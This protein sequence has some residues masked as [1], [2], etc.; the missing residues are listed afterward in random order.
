MSILHGWNRVDF[1]VSAEGVPIASSWCYDWAH[2]YLQSGLLDTEMGYVFK[3]FQQSKVG[4]PQHHLINSHCMHPCRCKK[5]VPQ[6]DVKKVPQHTNPLPRDTPSPPDLYVW[7]LLKAAASFFEFRD[8]LETWKFTKAFPCPE[9]LFDD[10]QVRLNLEKTDFATGSSEL[11]SLLPVFLKYFRDTV[12][13]RGECVAAVDSII[14]CLET[15]EVLQ[16]CKSGSANAD[17]LE[18]LDAPKF[19][20]HEAAGPQPTLTGR[21]RA[22][23]CVGI[24]SASA[25]RRRSLDTDVSS[26]RCTAAI[27]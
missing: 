6:H 7:A 22:G 25:C 5:K 24:L 15:V 20:M 23:S 26:T 16:A 18:D 14:A 17:V 21:G 13:P 10:T 19:P 2:T 12:R 4:V 8:F 1:C 9:K 3:K 11:L 27:R